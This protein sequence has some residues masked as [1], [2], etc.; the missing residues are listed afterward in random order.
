M[1]DRYLRMAVTFATSALLACGDAAV[2][3][4][5]APTLAAK[6]A[7]PVAAQ[8]PY[9]WELEGTSN[10]IGIQMAPST[11][12]ENNNTVFV[13]DVR[14]TFQ[15]ANDV[16]AQ[17]K[18]SLVNENGTTVNSAEAAMH[19]TR[20][21][22]P[23]VSGDTTFTLRVTTSITCGLI[24]KATYS[25]SAKTIALDVRLVQL[26]LWSQSVGPTTAPDVSQP[27]CP[28]PPPPPPDECETDAVYRLNS[29]VA[30]VVSYEEG[31]DEDPPTAPSG[32][33]EA[34][35]APSEGET[36]TI[37]YT[38]WREYWVYDYSTDSLTLMGEWLLGT[39]CVTAVV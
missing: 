20:L 16:S 18:A 21:A 32:G 13:V 1:P 19:Y 31:C 25:G 10:A 2:D 26:T 6:P 35:T 4:V 3:D 24:G 17:V 28:P 7:T 9:T 29:S 33:E 37:C 11:R 8:Y 5:T 27:A 22:V 15:W 36:I 39:Y 34:P 30:P 12:F 23:V 14:V 38:V